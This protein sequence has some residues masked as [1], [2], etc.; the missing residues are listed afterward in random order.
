MKKIKETA[1]IILFIILF[2]LADNGMGIVLTHLPNKDNRNLDGYLWR[3]LYNQ[4][5]NSIDIMFLGSSH[6]RFSFDTKKFNEKLGMNTFNLSTADQTPVVGYYALQQALRHQSPKV[7]VYEAYTSKMCDDSNITAANF[8]YYYLKDYDIKLKMLASLRKEDKFRDFV[9]NS[10][11][12]TYRF[13]QSFYVWAELIRTHKL[14]PAAVF[15]DK[16]VF[17]DIEYRGDGYLASDKVVTQEN[18]INSPFKSAGNHVFNKKQLDYFG[19]AIDL[20]K[21]KGIKVL[22][23]TAPMPKAT[24]DYIKEY[25]SLSKTISDFSQ[26]RGIKYIDYNLISNRDKIFDDSCF[27]DSNHLNTKGASKLDNLLTDTLMEYK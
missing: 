23:V 2:I 8:V 7:L 19:K 22:I 26:K 6:A 5:D 11:I 25:N 12:K 9:I 20:C 1:L 10:N 15:A 24:I 21:A 3:D 4:P 14:N 16:N 27:R 17:D 18:L 13:R